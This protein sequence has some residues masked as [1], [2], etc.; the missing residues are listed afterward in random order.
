MS[1]S[2]NTVC[3]KSSS[4]SLPAVGASLASKIS[5]NGD[6]GNLAS[7]ARPSEAFSRCFHRLPHKSTG[8]PPCV[9]FLARPLTHCLFS[10]LLVLCSNPVLPGS[11]GKPKWPR[12]LWFLFSPVCP[13]CGQP[14]L[15]L[16]HRQYPFTP[17]CK[18]LPEPGNGIRR[19]PGDTQDSHN[20]P[21][22]LP[23]PQLPLLPWPSS[24][25]RLRGPGWDAL[26][27]PE[28][29]ISSSS[30]LFPCSPEHGAACLRSPARRPPGGGSY[31]LK[32]SE[33]KNL[34]NQ[35]NSQKIAG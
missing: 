27:A 5:V 23:R 26:R 22:T 14:Q 4:F 6:A 16:K 7:Q 12:S 29:R 34:D 24:E 35:R 20:S 30:Q 11:P 17:V 21:V 31:T 1:L 2:D 19:P 18:T 25:L 13:F 32:R 8:R 9:M 10:I 28:F 33:S 3:H 15:L